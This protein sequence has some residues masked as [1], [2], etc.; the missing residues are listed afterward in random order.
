MKQRPS[1]RLLILNEEKRLLLFKFEH[2][3]GPLAGQ[4]FW[5]TPGGALE[6]GEDFEAA[7]ERE[8]LE[9]VGI[10]Q[11]EIG[12][13]IAQR[14]AIFRAPDGEMIEA[15]ERYFLFHVRD[16]FVSDDNWTELERE[17]MGDHRW[18]TKEDLSSCN[19][20]IWPEDIADLLVR[21]GEWSLGR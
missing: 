17:V 3:A 7:A 2:K 1:S 19:E 15:D 8:L 4:V 18:W 12:P 20:Q 6:D 10:R 21:T 16:N 9:E 14:T 5:A 11:A 13:Q